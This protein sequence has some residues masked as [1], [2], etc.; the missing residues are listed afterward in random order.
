MVLPWIPF[1]IMIGFATA[2]IGASTFF[3]H[4]PHILHKPKPPTVMHKVKHISHRGGSCET[5][6]N[7][8]TAFRHAIKKGT[9]MLELDVRL[10]KDKKVVVHH[11]KNLSRLT[12][13]NAD[14]DTLNYDELPPKYSSSIG[15]TFEPGLVVDCD[16]HDT[17]IALLEEVFQAFPGVPINV[18]IKDSP[19]DELIDETHKL[20]KKY[21]REK[22][23]VWGSFGEGTVSKCYKKDPEIPVLFSLSGVLKVVLLHY[24]GLLPFVPLKESFL[25]IPMY[26]KSPWQTNSRFLK[27]VFWAIMNILGSPRLFR[28]LNQRGILVFTWVQNTEEDMEFCFFKKRVNAVMTDKP[29]LLTKYLEEK[30]LHKASDHA[31]TEAEPLIAD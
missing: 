18:D 19:P 20:I 7:T 21:N 26:E 14:I 12:G 25:E 16:P 8:L 17:R 11:D 31:P 27:G 30:G 22:L 1:V 2:Y 10:T 5:P 6:E 4:N 24:T 9:Q 23:T 15:V 29:T 13:V 28:H 3:F